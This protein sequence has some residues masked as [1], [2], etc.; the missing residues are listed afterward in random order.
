MSSGL[1]IITVNGNF[2]HGGNDSRDTKKVTKATKTRSAAR[3]ASSEIYPF[4]REMSTYQENSFWVG[5]FVSM[6]KA[7]FP[8]GVQIR[9]N[10]E[11]SNPR[12]YLIHRV[13]GKDNSCPI[14]Q[15]SAAASLEIRQFLMSI[16]ILSPEDKA[17]R[18]AMTDAQGD[19]YEAISSWSK[20]KSEPLRITMIHEYANVYARNFNLTK[21]Q[22]LELINII[23]L[24]YSSKTLPSSS[25]RVENGRLV[26]I[27]GIFYVGEHFTIAAPSVDKTQDG[28]SS[29][30]NG[31]LNQSV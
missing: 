15:D 26:E 6:S 28:L 19:P 22:L 31:H 17:Q 23:I 4:F 8:K 1:S 20:I 30:L 24:G 3:E 18:E 2:W 27:N 21:S 25:F 16:G 11:G 10:P 9:L 29:I 14:I 13:R 5:I 12:G 7:D